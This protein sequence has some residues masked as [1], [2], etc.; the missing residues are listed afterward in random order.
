[1][2][3]EIRAKAL[4]TLDEIANHIE[5]LNTAGSGSRWLDKFLVRIQAYAK[6]NVLYALCLNKNLQQEISVVS[7]SAIGWWLLKL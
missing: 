4:K 1:M 3:I 5:S 6:P 7:P 2:E